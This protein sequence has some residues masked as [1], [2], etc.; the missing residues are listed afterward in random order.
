[1]VAAPA[2]QSEKTDPGN[3]SASGDWTLSQT[4]AIEGLLAM[5]Q[6]AARSL[7]AS[8]I[9]RLDTDGALMLLE[10]AQRLG[11]EGQHLRLR[12][13]HARLVDA[14]RSIE[15]EKAPEAALSEPSWR[16]LLAHIGRAM[17]TILQ[18]LRDLVA[19]FGLV[20]VALLRTIIKPGRLRLTATIYH[21][22]HTGIDA[23]PL[24]VVLSFLVGAVIAFLG[25]TVMRDFGAELFVVELVSFA[26]LREFG[27][28]LTAILL[29]GRTAS[30]FTAQI[31][32]MKGREEIDAIRT[33][34]LDVIDLLVVP[35]VIALLIMLPILAFL[36]MLAGIAGGMLVASVSLDIP[37]D[38]F[39]TRLQESIEVRHFL[40]GMSKA[41]VFALV[42]AL[43]GCLEG[44]K[45]AGTAQSVGERTTSSVVQC[46]ALVIVINAIAAVFFLETGL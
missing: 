38:L 9:E 34:G 7:D 1:M 27:T 14:V 33:M 17:V 37:V 15:V 31:G 28:L 21:M 16:L 40:V 20:L 26:F 39:I 8:A 42:I 13:D 11:V 3:W 41:P 35:R 12:E 46:I 4:P 2:I 18:Q 22:E 5:L 32:T 30:A 36:A 23:V 24:V 19:F 44:F 43:V 25:A 6:G 45:V 29:A 10:A